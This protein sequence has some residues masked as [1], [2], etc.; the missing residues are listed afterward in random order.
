[1]GGGGGGGRILR[2]AFYLERDLQTVLPF[3]VYVLCI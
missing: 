3:G 1:M 2:A